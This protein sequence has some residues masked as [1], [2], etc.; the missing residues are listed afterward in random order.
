MGNEFPSGNKLSCEIFFRV[1]KVGDFNLEE[2]SVV[3][4][5][6]YLVIVLGATSGFLAAIGSAKNAR[7]IIWN[8]WQEY[9]N[10]EEDKPKIERLMV[11]E[12]EY[13]TNLNLDRTFVTRFM[14]NHVCSIPGD[15]NIPSNF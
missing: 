15:S 12:T 7:Q 6:P 4:S 11:V 3:F 2:K 10:N 8:Q 9:R 1:E 13:F 14:R 5:A